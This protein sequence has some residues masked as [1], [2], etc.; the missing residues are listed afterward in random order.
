[1]GPSAEK[2]RDQQR[3]KSFAFSYSGLMKVKTILSTADPLQA[4]LDV[5]PEIQRLL[6]RVDRIFRVEPCGS[7]EIRLCLKW[8]LQRVLFSHGLDWIGL[9]WTATRA[10][11]KF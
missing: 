8:C 2:I 9:D 1:M 10:N 6:R 7:P 5:R 3:G 11:Y 4:P